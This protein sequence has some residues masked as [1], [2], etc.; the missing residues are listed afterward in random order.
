MDKI[1][2][3]APLV[4]IIVLMWFILIRPQRKREKDINAM[5]A[6]LKVGDYIVTIGGL[7]GRITKIKDDTITLA[8]GSDRVK[9]DFARWAISKVEDSSA[10]ATKASRTAP[11]EDVEEESAAKKKPRKLGAVA[12]VATTEVEPDDKELAEVTDEA[13]EEYEE[14]NVED[15]ESEE[16]LEEYSSEEELENA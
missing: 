6:G 13:V 9:M 1:M 4:I 7:K 14:E 15:F 12:P 8:V 11:E 5:R 10:G 2:Q 3:F 16:L